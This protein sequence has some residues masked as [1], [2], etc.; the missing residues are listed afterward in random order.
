VQK[1]LWEV[2]GVLLMVMI[3]GLWESYLA[4]LQSQ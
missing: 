2:V 1:V 4:V 3:V